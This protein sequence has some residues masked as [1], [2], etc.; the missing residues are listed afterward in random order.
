[1]TDVTDDQTELVLINTRTNSPSQ[2]TE[3]VMTEGA[4]VSE[5]PVVQVV[6]A[7]VDS[8]GETNQTRDPDPRIEL[9]EV[10]PIGDEVDHHV[11]TIKIRDKPRTDQMTHAANVDGK[12]MSIA[13][14]VRRSIR[15][16]MLAA[17]MDISKE[18]VVLLTRRQRPRRENEGS[19]VL[20]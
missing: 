10:D 7:D 4:I 8:L 9:L 14:I 13:M 1:M 5:V 11:E 15:N 17:N 16:V 3:M 6:D 18:C 19:R 2:T 12:N 20:G